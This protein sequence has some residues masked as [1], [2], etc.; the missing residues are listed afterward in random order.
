MDNDWRR[1]DSPAP[2]PPVQ[3]AQLTDT[4]PMHPGLQPMASQERLLPTPNGDFQKWGYPNSWMI[5]G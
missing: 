5:L 4:E 1:R 2:V 3:M